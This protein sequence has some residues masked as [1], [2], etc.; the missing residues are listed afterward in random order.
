MGKVIED[1]FKVE[2]RNEQGFKLVWK[3]GY[4]SRNADFDVYQAMIYLP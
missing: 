3:V 1:V 2:R 4:K